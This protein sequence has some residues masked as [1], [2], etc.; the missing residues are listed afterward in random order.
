MG[1]E[2]EVV[3]EV[4]V[5]VVVVGGEFGGGDGYVVVVGEGAQG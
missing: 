4:G 2:E 5:F 3:A 1:F